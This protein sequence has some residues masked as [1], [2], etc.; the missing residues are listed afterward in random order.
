M[1]SSGSIEQLVLFI[2]YW[3][4]AIL[5]VYRLAY[6]VTA[7]TGPARIFQRLRWWIHSRY[8][9]ESWQYEGATCFFCQSVWY[10]AP[11]AIFASQLFPY[12]RETWFTAIIWSGVLWLSIA[13]AAQVLHWRVLVWIT[14][15]N[16]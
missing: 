13:G 12:M 11:A 1:V 16:K 3:L 2:I 8:G 4:A 5:A 10:A 15:V 6:M 7:D 9:A 14:K